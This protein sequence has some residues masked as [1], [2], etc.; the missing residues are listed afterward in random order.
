[1]ARQVVS[2]L[3]RGPAALRSSDP[4]LEAN[5]YAVAED[6]HLTLVLRGAGTEF[7][8][9][10]SEAVP[11][12]LAGTALPPAASGQD[13]RGLLES[14]VPVYAGAD[15]VGR[16]GLDVEDLVDGV[17]LLDFDGLAEVLRAADA[18]LVW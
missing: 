7:A 11:V 4:V 13:V 18:V 12:E 10:H 1:M 15:D 2:V 14:G 9:A 16:L 17:T 8:V 6:V 5:V 3:R